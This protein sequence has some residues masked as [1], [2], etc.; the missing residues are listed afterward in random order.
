VG[1]AKAFNRSKEKKNKTHTKIVHVTDHKQ[2]CRGGKEPF[3]DETFV[4]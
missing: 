3:L 4:K 1:E 2:I